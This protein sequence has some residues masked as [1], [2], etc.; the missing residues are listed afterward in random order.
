MRPLDILGAAKPVPFFLEFDQHGR[1]PPSPHRFVPGSRLIGRRH[2]VF[3]ALKD[4]HRPGQPV[5]EVH[6]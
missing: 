4:G 2:P 1:Q 6:R 3:E 5:G